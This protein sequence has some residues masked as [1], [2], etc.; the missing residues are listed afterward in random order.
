[1][2]SFARVHQKGYSAGQKTTGTMHLPFLKA[3]II[4]HIARGLLPLLGCIFVM[5]SIAFGDPPGAEGRSRAESDLLP[6]HIYADRIVNV[7][8][9][10]FYTAEGEV[11]I[12]KGDQMLRADRVV[13][14]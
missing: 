10:N 3:S 1:L 9:S 7:G 13:Y 14:N 6:W 11:I 2:R 4:N 5:I 8:D 12:L